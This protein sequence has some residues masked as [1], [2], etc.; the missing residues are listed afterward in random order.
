MPAAGSSEQAFERASFDSDPRRITDREAPAT[1]A[2]AAK[3]GDKLL[4]AGRTVVIIDQTGLGI[5][6]LVATDLN[7]WGRYVVTLSLDS[8]D[9]IL[10]FKISSD[11]RKETLEVYDA[12][13]KA[14]VLNLST[15]LS[16][17]RGL[18]GWGRK[19]TRRLVSNLRSVVDG[20]KP[21]K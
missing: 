16:M 15:G 17:W 14:L 5:T 6:D 12:K 1:A 9:L 4:Q 13:S 11:D 18:R 8:A 3:L 7:E 2:E 10:V 19:E 21:T 20:R